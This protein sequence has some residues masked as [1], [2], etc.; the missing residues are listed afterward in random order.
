MKR[1]VFAIYAL[2]RRT[3]DGHEDRLSNAIFFAALFLMLCFGVI[4]VFISFALGL[5]VDL[6]PL[7]TWLGIGVA[8]VF[9]FFIFCF[10]WL[11]LKFKF[12]NIQNRELEDIIS[13]SNYLNKNPERVAFSPLIVVFVLLMLVLVI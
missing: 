9:A 3:K 4:I 5:E 2:R 12:K 8:K 7:D 13:N 11:Y 10:I 1:I 6:K